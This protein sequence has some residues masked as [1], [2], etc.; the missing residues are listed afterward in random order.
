[1]GESQGPSKEVSLL[2]RNAFLRN[3]YV[4]Q[5]KEVQLY[6]VNDIV[7]IREKMPT[8]KLNDVQIQQAKPGDKPRKLVD[9]NGM[10]TFPN[11]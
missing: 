10:Y 4:N 6:T 1:M 9:G 5:F 7:I 8:N 3:L 2:R 11:P